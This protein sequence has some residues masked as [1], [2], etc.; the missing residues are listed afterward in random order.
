[1][2]KESHQENFSCAYCKVQRKRTQKKSWMTLGILKSINHRNIMFKKLK[3]TWPD[4][5][6]YVI[7]RSNFN[8]YG[9]TEKKH[10]SCK[11]ILLQKYV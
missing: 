4:S 1:M 11:T 9:S 8:H 5:E 6:N 7:K 3:Q 10:D 2:L